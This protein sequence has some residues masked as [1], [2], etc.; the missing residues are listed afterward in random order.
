M[1]NENSQNIIK[2]EDNKVHLVVGKKAPRIL[3]TTNSL[4]TKPTSVVIPDESTRDGR[5]SITPL[6][7]SRPVQVTSSNGYHVKVRIS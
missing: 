4:L 5:I 7:Q 2:K 1:I 6:T 3:R